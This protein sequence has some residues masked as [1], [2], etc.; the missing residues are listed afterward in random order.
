MSRN[1]RDGVRRCSD[2]SGKKV[3][4]AGFWCMKRGMLWLLKSQMWPEKQQQQKQ[5]PATQN[6]FPFGPG[7]GS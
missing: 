7:G 5:P 2:I 3:L 4:N 6:G 1:T